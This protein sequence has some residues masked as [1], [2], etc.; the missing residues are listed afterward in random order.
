MRWHNGEHAM[1]TKSFIVVITSLIVGLLVPADATAGTLRVPTQ[2]PTISAAIAAAHNGDRIIV[3]DGVYS[4]PGNRNLDV[5]GKHI[6]LESA[7]GS[8]NCVIDC[9]GQDRAFYFH[10]RESAAVMLEG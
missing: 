8:A 9:Q 10:N 1:F 7:S 3:A 6:R 5:A 4:G 2:Y